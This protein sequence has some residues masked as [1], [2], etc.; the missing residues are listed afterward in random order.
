[1][2]AI[3]RTGGKQYRVS[4]DD[5]LAVEHLTAEVGAT[6]NFDDVLLIGETDKAPSIG[7]PTLANASVAAE[8]LEQARDDKVRIIKFHRRKNYRRTKGH[9]QAL[10]IVK[11]TDI[12][13]K[14]TS[15]KTA[16]TGKG[17]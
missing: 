16:S 5:I 17:D 13:A 8:V 14:T 15:P 12:M 3:I 6:L 4:K 11:I 7:T 10:T 9:R 2:Y 1:M